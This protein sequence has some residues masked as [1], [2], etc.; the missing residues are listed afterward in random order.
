VAEWLVDA[1][2][3]APRVLTHQPHEP[4]HQEQQQ[5]LLILL[6]EEEEEEE[7]QQQ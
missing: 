1:Q 5:E 7:E 6:Q 2:V 3:A 4:E